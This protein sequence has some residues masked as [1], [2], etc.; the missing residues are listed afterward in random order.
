MK[1]KEDAESLSNVMSEI[2]KLSGIET[3]CVVTNMNQ[4]IGKAVRKFT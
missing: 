3:V 1:T 2:G 4:P